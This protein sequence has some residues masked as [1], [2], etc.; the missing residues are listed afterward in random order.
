MQQGR[1][2]P[3]SPQEKLDFA[4]RAIGQKNYVH[5]RILAEQ[6]QMNAQTSG[7]VHTTV[8]ALHTDN[9]MSAPKKPVLENN[10]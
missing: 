1:D 10:S 9:L 4:E 5:A 8:S 3:M 7:K 2:I 6:A